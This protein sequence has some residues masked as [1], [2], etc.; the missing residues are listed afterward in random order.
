MEKIENKMSWTLEQKISHALM[1]I[2]EYYHTYEGKVY[3]AFSGGKDSCVLKFL[4]DKF[5]DMCGYKRVLGVFNNTTNEHR[6]I[7]DFIKTFGNEILTIRPKMTFAQ[8]IEK[9]GYPLVSKEQAQY[10]SEAKTTKSEKL[11]KL[12]TEGRQKTSK[13]GGKYNQGKISDKWVYLVNEEIKITSKCCDILKKDPAKRFEKETGLKPIVGTTIQESRLREQQYNMSGG[14]CNNYGKNPKSKPLSIFTKKDI[15]DCIELFDIKYCS[16]YDDQEIDGVFVNG[17]D[18]TGCAYCAFGEQFSEPTNTKFH[19]LYIREPKRYKSVMD[20]LGFRDAL[21][22][23]GIQLPD[24]P[25]QQ[26]R[27]F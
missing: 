6:E 1:N 24:D 2:D 11:F 23:V 25:N 12:R 5:T 9:Y 4:I 22:K 3:Y 26:Q 18:R 7:L 10:I 8:T 13:K 14:K 20:K 16:I 19:R 27:L 15:W 21:H 17:E